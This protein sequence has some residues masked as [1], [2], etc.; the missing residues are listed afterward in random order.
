MGLQRAESASQEGLRKEE[1]MVLLYFKRMEICFCWL[2]N[3][4]RL[5]G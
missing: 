4:L 1:Y 2:A 5:W 3:M